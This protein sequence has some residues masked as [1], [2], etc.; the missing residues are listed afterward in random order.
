ML[1]SAQPRLKTADPDWEPDPVQREWWQ[2]FRTGDKGWLVR[3]DGKDMIRMHRGPHVEDLRP[4]NAREWVPVE[5]PSRLTEDAIARIAWEADCGLLRQLGR[6]EEA[7]RDW[8]SLTHKERRGFIQHGPDDDD[9]PLRLGLYSAV[10][11]FI[12]LNQKQER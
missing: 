3:R 11:D 2:H 9:E 10:T 1:T 8:I 6:Y 12:R 7:K 5:T 4:F